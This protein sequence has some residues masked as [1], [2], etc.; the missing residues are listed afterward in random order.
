M[1]RATALAAEAGD[2]YIDTVLVPEISEGLEPGPDHAGSRRLTRDFLLRGYVR[3]ARAAGEA[4]C[5]I[6]YDYR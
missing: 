2:L 1:G 3:S 5:D 6:F 4:L